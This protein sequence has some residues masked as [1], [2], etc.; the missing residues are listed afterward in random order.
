[1]NDQEGEAGDAEPEEQ[2]DQVEDLNNELNELQG[3]DGSATMN[4]NV[5]PEKDY[6]EPSQ[7]DM[8]RS[9]VVNAD[10]VK[11]LQKQEEESKE[12]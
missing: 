5:E 7:H 3:L 11:K 8:R 1:M 2:V 12:V 6:V 10:M 4:A 9:K